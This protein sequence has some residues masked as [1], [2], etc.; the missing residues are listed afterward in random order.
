[1]GG[2]AG[3]TKEGHKGKDG[4]GIGGGVYVE[5]D[6]VVNIAKPKLV[7]NN[8]TSTKGANTFRA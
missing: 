6:A 2:N 7:N 4:K 5:A 3:T 1:V 8:T